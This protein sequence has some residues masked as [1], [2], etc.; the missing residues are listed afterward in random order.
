MPAS[1]EK[2]AETHL[3]KPIGP[4]SKSS[5]SN[6][7]KV[8]IKKDHV[9]LRKF[10]TTD[11]TQSKTAFKSSRARRLS[12]FSIDLE[13]D[14]QASISS[15][16]TEEDVFYP[17]FHPHTK[18]N[19]IDFTDLEEFVVNEDEISRERLQMNQTR[20]DSQDQKNKNALKYT[21]T[22]DNL[23]LFGFE[24]PSRYSFYHSENEDTIHAANLRE[25]VAHVSSWS[26]LFKNGRATWWLDCTCP[27]DAEM[28][29]LSKAFGLH[30][31]TAED[32]RMQESREKVE[33][34][35]NYYFVCFHTFEQDQESEDYLE[36]I[37]IFIVVFREGVLTFKFSPTPHPANVRRR[38]RQLSD[39]V[40]VNS[41]WICY[42]LI[43]DITDAFAPVIR[44]IEYEADAIDDF[45]FQLR[46]S[47]FG[48]ML[49]RIGECRKVVMTLM[50]LL[51]NK[52][53]VIKMF[54]NRCSSPMNTGD[55]GSV[56]PLD[57]LAT[58]VES[59]FSQPR[60]DIA[61]YLGDIQDHI[62]TMFQ[63]L[64][65]YEKIFSR[66][67]SNYLSQLQVKSLDSGLNFSMLL[68]NLTILGSIFVPLNIITGLFGMNVL[69][70][71]KGGSTYWWFIGIVIVMILMSC[72]V[73]VLFKIWIKRNEKR[74]DSGDSD[75]FVTSIKSKSIKSKVR[76]RARS[77]VNFLDD[78]G[79]RGRT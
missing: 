54:A 31:L 45:V 76:Q 62:V 6:G 69:I 37:K 43:D 46:L 64:S 56:G 11:S 18:V 35:A 38:A 60:S 5:N 40:N 55:N 39:Y 32:I 20:R 68:E 52:A 77:V 42:A 30:P 36:P 34:F 75:S 17:H 65:A 15:Q 2:S 1:P 44:N 10:R 4:V 58:H 74:E 70:P 53:D 67:E 25:L 26:D 79:V 12:R 29:V 9:N 41:D 50:R 8:S 49:L 59:H 48:H 63:N 47:D 21:P 71:G 66:S 61:L 3:P 78:Y 51:T 22:R 72:T 33:L 23:G 19:G 24:I 13:V 7:P 14:S 28:K 16:E 27:T 73:F 57:P